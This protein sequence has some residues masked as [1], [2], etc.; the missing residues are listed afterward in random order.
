MLRLLFT[1]DRGWLLWC[2][3]KPGDG[4]VAL[5]EI[6]PFTGKLFWF[7]GKESVL[8]SHRVHSNVMN[9]NFGLQEN[10]WYIAFFSIALIPSLKKRICHLLVIWRTLNFSTLIKSSVIYSSFLAEFCLG[11]FVGSPIYLCNITHR[12]GKEN[13]PQQKYL[14]HK[15]HI[16][17]E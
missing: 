13:K 2:S 8:R 14:L 15:M 5:V 1:R 16:K 9:Q 10:T 11:V 17:W 12:S 4:E 6:Q 7:P 3:P